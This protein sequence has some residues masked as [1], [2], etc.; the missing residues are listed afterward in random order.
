MARGQH[1]VGPL[2]G[3]PELV[4]RNRAE[5]SI[6]LSE[7]SIQLGD[8]GSPIK[9]LGQCRCGEPRYV[10]ARGP[11]SVQQLIRHRDVDPCHAHIIRMNRACGA[12]NVKQPTP[13]ADG[14]AGNLNEASE[15]G[16]PHRRVTETCVTRLP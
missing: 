2:P 14:P 3:R 12:G 4:L 7:V 16:Q 9:L 5:L 10:Q 1:R 15:S 13:L 6:Q 11:G 8:L